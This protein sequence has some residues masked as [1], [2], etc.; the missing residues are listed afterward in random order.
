MTKDGR[1]ARVVTVGG[2]NEA[3]TPLKHTHTK[4]IYNRTQL[5][6]EIKAMLAQTDES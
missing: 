1:N 2:S 5:Q 6:T 3:L 4:Q